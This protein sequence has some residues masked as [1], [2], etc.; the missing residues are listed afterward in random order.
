MQKIKQIIEKNGFK[1]VKEWVS[2]FGTE[3][4]QFKQ[5]NKEYLCS[6]HVAKRAGKVINTSYVL[7]SY[8]ETPNNKTPIIYYY[9]GYS[10]EGLLRAIEKLDTGSGN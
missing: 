10:K 3:F 9:N 4:I 8:D 5:N 7:S 6:R 2:V 1:I